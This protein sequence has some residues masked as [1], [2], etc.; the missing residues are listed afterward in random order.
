MSQHRAPQRLSMIGRPSRRLLVV[1]IALLVTAGTTWFSGAS[2]TAASDTAS[3]VRA[4]DDYYPPR[5]AVS[6]P[7]ATINGV[8]AISATASDTGSGVA[9]VVLQYAATGSTTWT[10][11]CTD[12]TS[13]YS[14][15]WDTATVADGD[16][17]LRAIATDKVGSSTTSVVVATKVANPAAV[18]L[19]T[20]ADVVRGTVPLSATVTGAAGRTVSS[21]FQIRLSGAAGWTTVS[22]CSA[23]SG[24]TPTC[25][26]A[27][28]TLAD[29]Y[30]VRVLS[31]VGSGA[32]AT[33]V[34]D[35]QADV[36]VD[37]LAPT[38]TLTAPAP[39]SGTV[40]VVATPLDDD[41]GIAKVDLS[42]RLQGTASWTALC[43]VSAD[44]YRC[45]LNTTTLVN[46][47]SYELRAIATDVAGNLSADAII[48]RTVNNGVASITITSPVTGDRVTGTKT[49]TTDVAT[50]LGTSATSVRIEGRLAGGAFATICTD[51]SAPY[52][53]DW[54]TSALTSGTWE[55]RGILTYTGGLTATSPVVTVTID[56]NP[57][58][59]LDIQASNGGT[60]G[61][62]G[63]GDVLTFTYLGAVDL[64]TLKA[65]WTGASTPLTM[66]VT[67]KAVAAATATDRATFTVPLG[68]VLFAQNYVR[69]NRSVAIPA[70][71]TA[72]NGTSGGQT[73]TIIT[74][75]LGT[76]SSVDLRNSSTTGAMRWTPSATV[77]NAAGFACSTATV[78]ETGA[79]D[80]D[81]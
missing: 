3:T 79:T 13:P 18:A 9:Q 1:L 58:R 55:L 59:A 67:D 52:T 47:G 16:Y 72:T 81:L 30:D 53:C 77:K 28:G 54:A 75:V 36:T 74:V 20:I 24:T 45:A 68:T 29:L 38:V 32:S 40:Q 65:G 78:T 56:N 4:A 35:E 57:L 48:T 43:T 2:F 61:T 49:I 23:V 63:A 21:A 70:T 19:T 17:Q 44:P 64:S 14:C 60:S 50:P 10:T 76:V 34:T 39:M 42:Y 80:R 12:T 37:N 66:N 41:S 22:G 69:A 46:L 62:A 11:L 6:T 73:T 25:S 71:M 5:V 51:A 15:S 26:W 7:A 8:V 27:T 33:T 31:T